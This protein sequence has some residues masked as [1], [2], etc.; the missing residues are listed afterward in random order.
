MRLHL[1][2]SQLDFL[3]N[4]FGGAS[5]E[6]SQSDNHDLCEQGKGMRKSTN[7]GGHVITEEALLPYFQVCDLWSF[8]LFWLDI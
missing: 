6:S 4:F 3:I 5:V 7:S 2:Q 1:H 8:C